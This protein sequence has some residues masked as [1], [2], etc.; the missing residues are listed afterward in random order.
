[1]LLKN[2]N[3]LSSE[4]DNKEEDKEVESLNVKSKRKIQSL[5]TEIEQL[6]DIIS[7]KENE[8]KENHKYAELLSELYEKGIIDTEGRFIDSE[9]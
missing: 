9:I 6:K 1:M 7:Q 4:S 3:S 5:K 2:K 8:S